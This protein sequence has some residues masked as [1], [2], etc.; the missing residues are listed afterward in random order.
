MKALIASLALLALL[1]GCAGS[2]EKY[3]NKS[4]QSEYSED[5]AQDYGAE[6]AYDDIIVEDNAYAEPQ[7]YGISEA[8]GAGD[9]YTAGDEWQWERVDCAYKPIAEDANIDTS[10]CSDPYAV[11]IRAKSIQVAYY[12][13]LRYDAVS[14]YPLSNK[15]LKK[16]PR[17]N[18]IY[19]Y[20]PRTLGDEWFGT[21]YEFKGDRELSITIQNNE[22]QHQEDYLRFFKLDGGKVKIINAQEPC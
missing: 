1:S 16:L 9:A 5:G 7:N 17:S 4:N 14:E 22:C 18:Y 19:N 21:K 13:Y 6:Q 3:L 12:R 8:Y 15:L 11:T 20:A 10:G 2:L